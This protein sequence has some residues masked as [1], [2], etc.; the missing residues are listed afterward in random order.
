VR[1]R[2]RV[3]H[4]RNAHLLFK[5][6]RPRYR[7]TTAYLCRLFN[8]ALLLTRARNQWSGACFGE[9]RGQSKQRG[10]RR[11]AGENKRQPS[12]AYHH[13]HLAR[14]SSG[15]VCKWRHQASGERENGIWRRRRH[16]I[17]LG[18]ARGGETLAVA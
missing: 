15:S 10:Q 11:R 6:Q 8:A 5:H 2:K 16:I 18:C 17:A 7:T 9:H 3:A 14:V 13:H 4:R 1:W 12:R